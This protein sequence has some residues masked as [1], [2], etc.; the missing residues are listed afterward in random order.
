MYNLWEIKVFGSH[1]CENTFNSPVS[2][3]YDTSVKRIQIG[4]LGKGPL[5][6]L[7]CKCKFF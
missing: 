6:Q 7:I 2:R 3:V 4:K 1:L 5:L